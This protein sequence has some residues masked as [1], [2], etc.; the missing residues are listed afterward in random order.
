MEPHIEEMSL[1]VI[2]SADISLSADFYRAIGFTLVEEKH[3]SGPLHFAAKVGRTVLEIYPLGRRQPT[4]DVRL[5]FFVTG[6]DVILERLNSSVLPLDTEYG[7]QAVLIDPDG[8]TIEL[9]E[10]ITAN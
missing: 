2:R 4:S 3:G 9:T 10:Q 1:V 6:L 8:H 5:G 7:Y